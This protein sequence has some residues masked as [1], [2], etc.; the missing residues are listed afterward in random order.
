MRTPAANKSGE[1]EQRGGRKRNEGA[2]TGG[3]RKNGQQERLII[4]K[5]TGG[6]N[7]VVDDDRLREVHLRGRTPPNGDAA[8][9]N[10]D[11][12]VNARLSR[13]GTSR[14]KQRKPLGY[15]LERIFTGRANSIIPMR[16]R[17]DYL[18]AT[19][20]TARRNNQASSVKSRYD[21]TSCPYRM[22]R[23][24][25]GVIL[26]RLASSTACSYS[27]FFGSNSG[28]GDMSRAIVS[29]YSI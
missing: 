26:T 13:S 9:N 28:A 6:K 29:D 10:N 12:T 19:V 15:H 18:A 14:T 22:I 2:C 5:C 21:D 4:E 1:Q 20:P 17:C 7:A 16:Y 27:S 3:E 11:K 25:T 24:R 23:E 8:I